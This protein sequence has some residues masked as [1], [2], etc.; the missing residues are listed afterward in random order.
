VPQDRTGTFE[1]Q[2]VAK[3]QIRFDGFDDKIIALYARGL[4]AGDIQ[5]QLE[6][7]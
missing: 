4:S 6:E 3:R 5:H 7:L 2:I 1:P